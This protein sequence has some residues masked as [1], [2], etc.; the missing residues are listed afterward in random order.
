M[1]NFPLHF[2]PC[3][4]NS[5]CSNFLQ[6][7][8]IWMWMFDGWHTSFNCHVWYHIVRFELHRHTCTIYSCCPHQILFGQWNCLDLFKSITRSSVF[9][10]RNPIQMAH[11]IGELYGF[12]SLQV[13]CLCQQCFHLY[14]NRSP[15]L[16]TQTALL[17]FY[18]HSRQWSVCWR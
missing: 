4:Y 9:I 11:S 13:P 5:L 18:G 8:F 7:W 16:I 17:Y 12:Y 3:L 14:Y 10:R 1:N 2:S 15:S 6:I